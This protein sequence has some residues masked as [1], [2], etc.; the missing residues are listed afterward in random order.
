M[1]R[2]EIETPEPRS[3]VINCRVTFHNKS[4]VNKLAEKHVVSESF[5]V[6]QIIGHF[7]KGYS[8]SNK[9]KPKRSNRPIY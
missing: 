3:E 9:G 6:D 5:I 1:K 2:F 8:D 7:K 4:F